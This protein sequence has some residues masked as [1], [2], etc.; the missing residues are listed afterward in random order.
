MGAVAPGARPGLCSGGAAAARRRSLL[1]AAAIFAKLGRTVLRE[2][3]GLGGAA[4][5]GW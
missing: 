3:T 5:C 4:A 2:G 1:H